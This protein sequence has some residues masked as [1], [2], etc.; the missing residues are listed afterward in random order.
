MASV[1]A[2]SRSY[3]SRPMSSPKRSARRC[4]SPPSSARASWRSALTGDV[5]L[6]LLCNTLATGAILFVADH[7]LRADLRRALQSGG[8]VGLACCSARP[9]MTAFV[10]SRRASRWARSSAC[11]SRMRCSANPIFAVG[12]QGA[13][14]RVQC[15]GGRRDVRS[16]AHHRGHRRSQPRDDRR[17]VALYIVAA[18]WFT[19]ST[20]FANPAVTLA[21]SLTPTFSGIAPS[22][23]P[24]YRGAIAR[25]RR[26]LAVLAHPLSG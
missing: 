2:D 25:R 26:G 17:L 1:E 15:V 9:R 12:I 16:R 18:Y 21:R 14:R 5:A 11:G 13:H 3:P 8:D 23:R 19:A 10:L 22:M 20:S 7:A 24:P 4:C 6:R